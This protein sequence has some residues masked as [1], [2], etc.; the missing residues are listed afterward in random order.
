VL[1]AHQILTFHV[2]CVQFICRSLALECAQGDNSV[3][4]EDDP[5]ADQKH[6]QDEDDGDWKE[7]DQLVD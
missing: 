1:F 4:E 2:I 7:G 3:G 6:C 5:E